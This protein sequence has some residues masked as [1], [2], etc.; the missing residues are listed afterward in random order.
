MLTRGE[1][2]QNGQITPA[3]T[4]QCCGKGGVRK[5]PILDCRS[6]AKCE[7]SLRKATAGKSPERTGTV[8]KSGIVNAVDMIFRRPDQRRLPGI[9][10]HMVPVCI[11]WHRIMI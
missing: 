7:E 11:P 1:R 2:A 10:D 8:K 3:V 4:E 9:L 6:L 5:R